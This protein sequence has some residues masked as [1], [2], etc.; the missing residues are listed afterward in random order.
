[1]L[2]KVAPKSETTALLPV[3]Q[4]RANAATDPAMEMLLGWVESYL[5]RDHP[6]LGRTGAVCPFTRQAAKMDTVRLAI[7][8]AGAEDEDEAFSLIRRAF[9]ELE[10]ISCK[11]GMEHFRT[12]IVGFPHAGNAE[13]IAMLQRVQARHKFYSLGRFR[14]IGFM[15][16]GNDAEGLWNPAFRPLR[17][18]LPVLA[19]RHLVEQDAPFAV[20]HPL[21]MAPYLAKFGFAGAKRLWAARRPAG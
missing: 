18:P 5:M 3:A 16:E 13:G 9:G 8:H 14:M 2:D 7:C 10:R 6:D 4:A 1:M 21:L 20:R 19:I 17:A 15:H 11:P 12:V